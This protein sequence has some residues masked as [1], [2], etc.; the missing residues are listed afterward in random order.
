MVDELRGSICIEL[1]VAVL[2]VRHARRYVFRLGCYMATGRYT[3][4]IDDTKST[5]IWGYIDRPHWTFILEPRF[6]ALGLLLVV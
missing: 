1:W 5:C 6:E 3:E 4:A 2:R